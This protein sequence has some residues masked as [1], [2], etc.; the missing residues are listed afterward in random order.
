M[1]IRKKI[2]AC[3]NHL[4]VIWGYVQILNSRATAGSEEKKWLEQ[5]SEECEQLKQGLQELS[6]LQSYS[7][8]PE[9]TESVS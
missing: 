2:H 6:N 3:N 1:D 8:T 7:Q 9:S 5:I 4:A